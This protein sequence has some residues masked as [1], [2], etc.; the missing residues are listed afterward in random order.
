M[1]VTDKMNYIFFVNCCAC[2][3]NSNKTPKKPVRF[4]EKYKFESSTD[5]ENGKMIR[6][7]IDTMFL[8][9]NFS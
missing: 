4:R 3:E 6:R 8:S 5:R 2:S 9:N 1:D 7:L